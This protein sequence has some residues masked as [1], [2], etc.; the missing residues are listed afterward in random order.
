[1]LNNSIESRKDLK[2]WRYLPESLL[3]SKSNVD[4]RLVSCTLAGAA[5]PFL[6]L[7][8]HCRELENEHKWRLALNGP[9]VPS[10]SSSLPQPTLPSST[11]AGHPKHRLGDDGVPGTSLPCRRFAM[12]PS[13]T[14]TATHYRRVC[15]MKVVSNSSPPS[16]HTLLRLLTLA[17]QKDSGHARTG[18]APPSSIR[19]RSSGGGKTSSCQSPF[20]CHHSHHF[21]QR[22][23][24]RLALL[25]EAAFLLP[26]LS[27]CLCALAL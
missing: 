26:P 22:Q 23:M 13:A 27:S 8:P 25:S 6:P 18:K 15:F 14:S 20:A 3:D 11:S 17:A 10:V 9:G 19:R 12:A 1:M 16:P 4:Y 21:R 2:A 24:R 5:P 7:L